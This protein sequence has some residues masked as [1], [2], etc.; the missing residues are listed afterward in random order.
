MRVP[1]AARARAEAQVKAAGRRGYFVTIG[2]E[3][4]ALCELVED[5]VIYQE[6]AVDGRGYKF[7]HPDIVDRSK[8]KST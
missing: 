5:G 6:V 4:A 2:F 1:E 3:S 7:T 8:P